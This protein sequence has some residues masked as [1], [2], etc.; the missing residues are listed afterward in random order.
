VWEVIVATMIVELWRLPVL[1][2]KT[3]TG[4]LPPC[5]DPLKGFRF[6]R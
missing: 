1:F 3:T 2:C 4:L 6:A 5:S